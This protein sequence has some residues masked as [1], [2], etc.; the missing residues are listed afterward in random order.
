MT[1]SNDITIIPGLRP[2]FF[3]MRP[4]TGVMIRSVETIDRLLDQ[5]KSGG[6]C[7]LSKKLNGDRCTMTVYDGEV[8]L[9]NRHGSAFKHTVLN[10]DDFSTLPHLTVLDGEVYQRTF[11]VFE[12]LIIGGKSLLEEGVRVRIAEA[13]RIAEKYDEWLFEAPDRAW[14]VE[15][16]A[17]QVPLGNKCMWEGV[18]KKMTGRPYTIM[19][20]AGQESPDLFRHK[21]V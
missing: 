4:T 15:N 6:K 13:K 3:P 1:F 5:V 18:V 16:F 14:L 11:Y 21:W 20:S 19:G 7:V 9:F 17:S 10:K 12:A 8:Y 2:T